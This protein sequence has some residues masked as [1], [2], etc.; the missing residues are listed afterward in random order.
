MS[1]RL[2][3]KT[4]TLTKRSLTKPDMLVSCPKKGRKTGGLRIHVVCKVTRLFPSRRTYYYLQG[5]P[6]YFRLAHRRGGVP[7]LNGKI[8]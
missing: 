3:K 1:N 5:G 4:S 6:S 2:P 7:I 8:E